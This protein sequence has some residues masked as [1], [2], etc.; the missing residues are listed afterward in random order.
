MTEGT[1]PG[2]HWGMPLRI[3]GLNPS[4]WNGSLSSPDSGPIQKTLK[5]ISTHPEN[6]FNQARGSDLAEE[7]DHMF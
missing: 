7:V 5:G 1:W 3:V 4:H 2:H 6:D